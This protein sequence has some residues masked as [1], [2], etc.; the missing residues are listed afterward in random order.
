MDGLGV[1]R[2]EA[3]PDGDGNPRNLRIGP[4]IYDTS[5][6]PGTNKESDLAS[7]DL[8]GRRACDLS[9]PRADHLPRP[10]LNTR[11]PGNRCGAQGWSLSRAVTARGGNPVI[12]TAG[13][14]LSGLCDPPPRQPS[15][16]PPRQPTCQDQGAKHLS[17]ISRRGLARRKRENH[18]DH[19]RKCV[20]GKITRRT[21]TACHPTD[22]E[23]SGATSS[24]V[25][26]LR[27]L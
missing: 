22:V 15:D 2:T 23:T 19:D 20:P 17:S 4:E 14:Q 6:A 9:A 18:H 8:H 12:N 21:A 27:D 7:A 3:R 16:P 13:A 10:R 5:S 11:N 25:A 1:S 24:N 26:G